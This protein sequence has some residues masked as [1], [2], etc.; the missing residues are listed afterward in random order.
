MPVSPALVWRSHFAVGHFRGPVVFP[1]IGHLGNVQVAQDILS[2]S[3][4][5][6][7]SLSRFQLA[8]APSGMGLTTPRLDIRFPSA[9]SNRRGPRSR[10]CLARFVPPSGFGY[11]LDGLLPPRPG[12]PCF[13]PTALM[14]FRPSKDLSSSGIRNVLFSGANEPACRCRRRSFR[15]NATDRP[16]DDSTSRSRPNLKMPDTIS[17]G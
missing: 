10:V 15:S 1:A 4:A 5:L 8:A 16:A 2:S 17:R 13:R 6:L 9:R 7:Q 12:Q 11:P 14:G 3:F